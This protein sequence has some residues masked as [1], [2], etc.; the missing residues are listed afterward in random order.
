MAE[1]IIIHASNEDLSKRNNKIQS[2]HDKLCVY[3]GSVN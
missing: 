1:K 2:Y 3:F